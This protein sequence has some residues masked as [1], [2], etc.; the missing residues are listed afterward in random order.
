MNGLESYAFSTKSSMEDDKIKGKVPEEKRAKVTS[1]C[2]EV[3]QWLDDNQTAKKEEI[4][5]QMKELANTF[6]RLHCY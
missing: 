2:Q 3:I 4:E 1:K 6:K 5:F